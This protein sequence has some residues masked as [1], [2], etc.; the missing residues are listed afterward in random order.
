MKKTTCLILTCVVGYRQI[1]LAAKTE[2][3]FT[4][5]KIDGNAIDVV[6]LFIIKPTLTGL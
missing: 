4:S 3:R 5:S 1:G 2:L 6:M